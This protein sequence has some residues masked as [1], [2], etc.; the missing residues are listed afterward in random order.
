V[1]FHANKQDKRNFNRFIKKA[2]SSEAVLSL[3]TPSLAR[4]GGDET[5]SAEALLETVCEIIPKNS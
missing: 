3:R 4:M 1:I 5:S 2:V